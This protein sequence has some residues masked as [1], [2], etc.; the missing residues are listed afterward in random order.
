MRVVAH[1]FV[2]S[3]AQPLSHIAA[4]STKTNEPEL[5]P[6]LPLS[7]TPCQLRHPRRLLA[8]R[9]YPGNRTGMRRCR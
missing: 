5:H 9:A 7:C 8:C 1:D 3:C 2:T 4:H 6:D